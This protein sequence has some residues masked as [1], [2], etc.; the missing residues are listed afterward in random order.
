[1]KADRFFI[2]DTVDKLSKMFML[3]FVGVVLGTVLVRTYYDFLNPTVDSIIG[4]IALY[5]V[6]FTFYMYFSGLRKK[7]VKVALFKDYV[8]VIL[9]SKGGISERKDIAYSDIKAYKVYAQTNKTNAMLENPNKD[10][11]TL[12]A[13]GYKTVIETKDGEIFEFSNS[14]DDGVMIYSPAYIYALIDLKRYY[15]DFNL[16][17]INFDS[18]RDTEDFSY[19][20]EYYEKNEKCLQLWQNKT[21]MLSLMQ[22]TILF[23]AFAFL[24]AAVVSHALYREYGNISGATA[25]IIATLKTLFAIVVPM[26]SLALTVS[27][28]GSKRNDRARTEIKEILQA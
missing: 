22:Y 2:V 17:L 10:K 23:C 7:T 9:A 11:Y 26:W 12:R 8:S 15:P 3:V 21:Y 24:V 19:Q 1:M 13:Y 16:E 4:V 27:V 28:Y 14:R 25:V 18:N 5:C 20:F 6:L